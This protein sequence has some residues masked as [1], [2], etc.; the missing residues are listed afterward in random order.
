MCCVARFLPPASSP[1]GRHPFRRRRREARARRRGDARAEARGGFARAGSA[2]TLVG[3]VPTAPVLTR[4]AILIVSRREADALES[5][6]VWE[7][8]DPT[9]ARERRVLS[10]RGGSAN[11]A[12]VCGRGF[13]TTR[14]VRRA[15]TPPLKT[16]ASHRRTGC[17]RRRPKGRGRGGRRRVRR[18]R[19]HRCAGRAGDRQGRDRRRARGGRRASGERARARRDRYSSSRDTP[20]PS[21]D[22][23][24]DA[25]V[26]RCAS[27]SRRC[28]AT[29]SVSTCARQRFCFAPFCFV[30]LSCRHGEARCSSCWSRG[31]ARQIDHHPFPPCLS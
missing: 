8:D 23:T 28:R 7:D 13:V 18:R 14:R 2:V 4:R 1:G 11:V 20:S 15:R 24:P 5:A 21:P 16:A 29:R 12:K 31:A 27:C 10:F 19:R 17:E 30:L 6:E 25:V 22:G 9:S 3:M 26:V